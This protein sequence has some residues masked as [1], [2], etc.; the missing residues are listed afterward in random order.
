M[1]KNIPM[2]LVGFEPMTLNIHS[3]RSDHSAIGV[4][5]TKGRQKIPENIQVQHSPTWTSPTLAMVSLNI[6]RNFLS[7]FVSSAS[8]AEWSERWECMFDVMGSNPI[9]AV[10]IFFFYFEPDNG[11]LYCEPFNCSFSPCN[12]FFIIKV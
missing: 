4:D 2:A 7:S 10:E 1:K 8:I 6:F 9:N 11:L 12:I 3:Q 5:D